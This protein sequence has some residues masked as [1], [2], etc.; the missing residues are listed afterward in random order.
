MMNEEKR[1]KAISK[2]LKTVIKH[3][4][5]QETLTATQVDDA[6]EGEL[7]SAVVQEGFA[8][9]A[10]IGMMAA[11]SKQSGDKS[12]QMFAKA[13]QAVSGPA[14]RSLEER[15][16]GIEQSLQSLSR[17]LIEQRS[18]IGALVALNAAGHLLAI[19]GRK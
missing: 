7:E 13:G 12:A 19:R 18:Q 16:E 10:S 1:K 4:K 3:Q 8:R 5:E 17:G 6:S 11:R 15:I 9:T 14:G 2:A